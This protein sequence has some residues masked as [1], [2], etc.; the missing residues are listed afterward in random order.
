RSTRGGPRDD[1]SGNR[2]QVPRD[3]E[4]HGPGATGTGRNPARPFGRRTL[5][6]RL[7]SRGSQRLRAFLPGWIPTAHV[8]EDVIMVPRDFLPRRFVRV[9]ECELGPGR[10]LSDLVPFPQE[11]ELEIPVIL[12]PV[13]LGEDEGAVQRMTRETELLLEDAVRGRLR[14]L[15]QQQV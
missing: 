1:S 4:S 11:D 7:R 13:H 8:C 12:R 9:D 5:V 10:M 14:R 3:R 15:T 6:G 2:R